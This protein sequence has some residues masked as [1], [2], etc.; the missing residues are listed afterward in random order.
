SK[1]QMPGKRGLRCVR[2]LAHRAGV[3]DDAPR[4]FKDALAFRRQSVKARAA[5]DEQHAKSVL[6]CLI[7]ADRVGWAAPQFSAARLKLR[8]R[9]SAIK[10]SGLAITAAQRPAKA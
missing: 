7:P 9:A 2:V 1:R 5:I 6:D 10:N 4:P 8:S 3:A